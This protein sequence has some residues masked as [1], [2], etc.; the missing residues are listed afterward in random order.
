MKVLRDVCSVPKLNHRNRELL[1]LR[2]GR[3]GGGG[4]GERGQTFHKRTINIFLRFTYTFNV[5]TFLI[6]NILFA[7]MFTQGTY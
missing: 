1:K 5:V 2:F 3:G 7:F 4:G 6:S